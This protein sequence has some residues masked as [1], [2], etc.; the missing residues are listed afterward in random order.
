[1]IGIGGVVYQGNNWFINATPRVRYGTF[2]EV[3]APFRS[4]AERKQNISECLATI[5]GPD[6]LKDDAEIVE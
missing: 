6:P 1:M 3:G 5:Y 2:Q 4:R